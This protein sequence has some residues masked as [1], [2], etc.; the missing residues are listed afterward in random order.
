VEFQRGD[1]M[2]ILRQRVCLAV[3]AMGMVG[4]MWAYADETPKRAS[5]GGSGKRWAILIGVDD[6]V[7][8]QDLHYCGADQKALHSRLQSAGFPED[9]LF[10]LHDS[11][12]ENRFKPF[13]ANIEKQLKLL[14]SLVEK[15]DL[16]VLGFSGHG[17]QIGKSAYLCPVD[18]NIEKPE[19]LLSLPD[20][21]EQLEKSPAALRLMIV[22]ACRNDPRPRGKR[23][24]ASIEELT[25][26]SK[27]KPPRGILW[28]GSCG[29][30][31]QSQ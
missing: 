26:F 31:Q 7:E 12:A 4:S 8:L 2:E 29:P 16:V 24:A 13:K 25:E 21:Y 9:H 27:S 22:D 10:L 28:L 3:L 19:T 18:A 6:Y 20:I 5:G 1:V 15:D 14:L 17:L 11:A 23:S 30:G